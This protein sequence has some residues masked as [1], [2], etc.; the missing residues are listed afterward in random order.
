MLYVYWL[1]ITSLTTLCLVMT[2]WSFL[3]GMTLRVFTQPT[4]VDTRRTLNLAVT[5]LLLVVTT[6]LLFSW[7]KQIDFHSTM[8]SEEPISS[9]SQTP[10]LLS[11]TTGFL[12]SVGLL[13]S[14]DSTPTITLMYV[15]IYDGLVTIVMP[16]SKAVYG[17]EQATVP[18]LISFVEEHGLELNTHLIQTDAGIWLV[19]R[20]PYDFC[21]LLSRLRPW[22]IQQS[23]QSKVT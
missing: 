1:V 12:S 16:D 10:S 5:S 21:S 6:L 7:G 19:S 13:P 23:G 9:T 22:F 15:R 8:K 17:I 20:T 3:S 18:S 14:P 2:L 11:E 4:T